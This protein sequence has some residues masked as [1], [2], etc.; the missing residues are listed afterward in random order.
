MRTFRPDLEIVPCFHR[1]YT[2][3]IHKGMLEIGEH[4]WLKYGV[5]TVEFQVIIGCKPLSSRKPYAYL[6]LSLCIFKMYQCLVSS[7]FTLIYSISQPVL[8]FA[9]KLK[10]LIFTSLDPNNLNI[11]I[12]H[13]FVLG[14]FHPGARFL[15]HSPLFERSIC[16]DSFDIRRHSK[17]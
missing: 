10:H 13:H 7:F 16:S 2:H 12:V 8:Y 14:R 5:W 11:E 4:T 3:S 9:T 1:I 6:P 15:I 17:F